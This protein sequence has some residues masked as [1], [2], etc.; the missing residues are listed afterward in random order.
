MII[1]IL[2]S[3]VQNQGTVLY[4]LRLTYVDKPGFGHNVKES[5]FPMYSWI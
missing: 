5:D 4:F 1:I 2:F 3:S